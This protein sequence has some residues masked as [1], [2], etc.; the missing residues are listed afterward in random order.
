MKKSRLWIA[1]LAVTLL[2]LSIVA[3]T[4]VPKGAMAEAQGIS[5]STSEA[6]QRIITVVGVGQVSL[7]PDIGQINVGVEARAPT[8]SETKAE[9]D[10][11]MAAI[12][13]TLRALGVADKDMQT[14]QYSIHYEREPVVRESPGASTGA[15]RVSSMLRL[16]VRDVEQVGTVLDA[17][18]EAGANQVY[19][20]QFTVSDDDKWQSEAREAAMADARSRAEELARLAGVT[21]GQVISVSEVIGGSPIPVY[22]AAAELA[23]GGGGIAPGELELSAQVQVTYAIQ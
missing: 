21:L 20:V 19:G 8:V 5:P 4:A 18:V 1:L 2:P 15:Y 6:V 3:C 23:Y 11:Q 13:E 17:A 7:A 12:V 9:I 10:R 16:T 14:S 22:R